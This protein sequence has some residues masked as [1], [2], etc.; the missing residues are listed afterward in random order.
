MVYVK[1]NT[2]R[3]SHNYKKMTAPSP[4]SVLPICVDTLNLFMFLIARPNVTSTTIHGHACV[5]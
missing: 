4:A 3:L 1:L 5:P 2:Q